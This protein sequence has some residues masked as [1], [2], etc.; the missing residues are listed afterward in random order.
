MFS[1]GE[2]GGPL[3]GAG[4]P[5]LWRFLEFWAAALGTRWEPRIELAEGDTNSQTWP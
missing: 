5:L 1:L 2:G 4:P 3:P